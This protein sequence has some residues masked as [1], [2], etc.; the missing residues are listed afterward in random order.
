M[1]P[2][3]LVKQ[4][5]K[6]ILVGGIAFVADYLTL[7]FFYKFVFG[8][9]AYGLYIGVAAGFVVGSVINYVLSSRIVFVNLKSRVSNPL[10][11]FC[12]YFLIGLVGLVLSEAG[13]S[14]GTVI[15]MWHYGIVKVLVSGLVLIWNFL[16]RRYLVYK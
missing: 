7:T 12:R 16:A 5:A 2:N 15:L 4:F 3:T 10:K 1:R 14:F 8:M 9:F 13:M 6:Y 11:E